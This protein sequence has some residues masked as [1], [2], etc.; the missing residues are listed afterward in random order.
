[1]LDVKELLFVYCGIMIMLLLGNWHGP[2]FD[3]CLLT[4]V[5]GF[6][7]RMLIEAKTTSTN[8]WFHLHH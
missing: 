1:M 8:N 2:V 6:I 3:I 4:R 7:F 5:V